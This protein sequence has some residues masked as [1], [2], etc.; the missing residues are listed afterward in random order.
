M[1]LGAYLRVKAG[2]AAAAL[3][4]VMSA[5][6]ALAADAPAEIKIG[7]LYSGSGQLSS[8]SMPVHAAL[9]YWANG[10]NKSGGVFVKAF[11]KKIPV[12]LIAYDDQSSPALAA[13]LA[14]QLITRDKVDILTSDSTSI[15]TASAVPVARDHKM[16]LFDLTGSSPKFFSADN[17]Y[18]VLLGLAATDRYAKSVVDFVP[19]MQKLGI[20]TVAFLY[21]T[22][23]YTAIQ[24]EEIRKAITAESGLKIVF[25]RGI[26]ANT[27]DY[28][29]LVNDVAAAK[30]DAFLE[31]GYP[32]NELA[33]LRALQDNG[34]KF[35]FL[36]TVYGLN[37]L[38]LMV[39][40]S[41]ADQLLYS[42]TLAGPAS[43]QFKVNYGLDLPHYKQAFIEW[44]EAHNPGVE[45]G[46][47]AVAGYHAGL[48]IEK[49]LAA[50]DSLDQLDLRKAVFSLSGNLETLVGKFELAPD[51]SQNGLIA[52]L[53]QLVANPKD[54]KGAPSFNIVAP[55]DL[56][57]AKPIYPAP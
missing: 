42:Y 38:P 33:F 22:A 50:A 25:D 3:A 45:F 49:T 5:S 28:T 53:G 37:E 55:P 51:G 34:V 30:P 2:I 48:V 9:E 40:N 19:Q 1:G 11:G 17:P 24:A 6:A 23:D 57:T 41:V 26:P 7:T 8:T 18:I 29:V 36:Y 31:F 10:V 44:A 46:Y 4:T 43:Y 13:N 35:N 52:P 12:R 27:T 21:L 54:P 56:A 47:N 15:M 20:K 16:L 14:N 39:T 32:A